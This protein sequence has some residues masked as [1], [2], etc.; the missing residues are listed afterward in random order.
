M[1][2][3]TK[4]ARV[5]L[6][7]SGGVGTMAA[8]ALEAGGLAEVT[9]VCRSNYDTVMKSGFTIDSIDHGH[10]ITGWRPSQVRNTVPNV[11]QEGLQYDFLVATTKNVPDVRPNLLDI[12]GPAI[13]PGHTTIVLLQNGINIEKPILEIFPSNIVLSGISM[14][15]ASETSYGTILHDDRDRVKLGP[16]PDQPVPAAKTPEAA[17]K[18]MELYTA[19]GKVAWVY[20]DDVKASRWRKLVYNSSFNSVGAILSMDTTRMRMSEF[21][22]DLLIRPAMLEIIQIAKANGVELPEGIE[23]EL[24]CTDKVDLFFVPSMGQDVV[25]VSRRAICSN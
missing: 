19:C 5:L 13:T 23:E 25:K 3:T 10:D 2:S 16:F 20:D 18:F 9:A 11:T 14:I 17:R 22:V 8:Y 7:G 21:V 24:V 4:K 6:I 15:Q 12:I 1:G